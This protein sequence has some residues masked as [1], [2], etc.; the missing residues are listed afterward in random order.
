MAIQLSSAVRQNLL[1]LQSTTDLMSMTQNRLA[2]GKKV[3]SALDDP[4]AFFTSKTMENR[5]SDLNN[6]LDN[7]GT[8]VETLKAADNALNAIIKLIETAQAN[9][10]QAQDSASTAAT[11]TGNLS[12]TGQTDIGANVVGIADADAFTVNGTT[13]T[14]ADGDGVTEL[15]AD[16]NAIADVS[17]SLNSSRSDRRYDHGCKQHNP[18]KPGF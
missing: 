11:T 9:V 2:T 14:I 16:L 7:V 13:I 8:A 10:T 3:N 12:L 17:A 4:T 6:I 15:L 5:A 18:L 1:S